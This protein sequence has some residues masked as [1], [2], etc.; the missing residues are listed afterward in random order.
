MGDVRPL[1]L[2]DWALRT[3]KADRMDRDQAVSRLD[4]LMSLPDHDDLDPLLLQL[5]EQLSAEPTAND[6]SVWRLIGRV[7]WNRYLTLPFGEDLTDLVAA[8]HS[9]H[10]VW[11]HDPAD[12]P[13][14]ARS[15]FERLLNDPMGVQPSIIVDAFLVNAFA[16]RVAY[17]DSATV[18]QLEEAVGAVLQMIGRTPD[19]HSVT[20]EGFTILCIA[21]RMQ[22][23]RT[24]QGEYIEDAVRYGERAVTVDRTGDASSS[25]TNALMR[26]YQLRGDPADLETA[27]TRAR[28][29]IVRG[30]TTAQNNLAVAL[31][32]RFTVAPNDSDA[33]EIVDLARRVVDDSVGTDDEALALVNLAINMA[34][35]SDTSY[36]IA[37][38]E[39]IEI[40]RR[41]LALAMPNSEVRRKALEM[42]IAG[43]RARFNEERNFD[44][45]D[46]ADQ[47]VAELA[48]LGGHDAAMLLTIQASL[49][50]TRWEETRDP[51]Q[52]ERSLMYCRAILDHVPVGHLNRPLH[53]HH[54]AMQLTT[55]FRNF[56]DPAYLLEAIA[57]H[58]S[59]LRQMPATH[60]LYPDAVNAVGNAYATLGRHTGD[61]AAYETA[62]KHHRALI[63]QTPS[64][65]PDLPDR[66]DSL[67]ASVRALGSRNGDVGLIDEALRYNFAAISAK[68]S[69]RDMAN[70]LGNTAD[71]FQTRFT[72][73]GAL[74]DIREAVIYAQRAVD[75]LQSDDPRRQHHVLRLG[76]FLRLKYSRT[77]DRDD[78]DAAIA[79]LRAA[80]AGL[81]LNRRQDRRMLHELSATLLASYSGPSDRATL[82]EAAELTRGLVDAVEKD[83]DSEVVSSRAL[84]LGHLCALLRRL[85]DVDRSTVLA[86][87]AVTTAERA[88]ELRNDAAGSP[89]EYLNLAEAL[90]VRYRLRRRRSD[91]RAALQTFERGGSNEGARLSRR[92]DC[93]IAGAQFAQKVGEL[94]RARAMYAKVLDLLP[95]LVEGSAEADDHHFRLSNVSMVGSRA[96]HAAIARS[97]HRLARRGQP[98]VD[99]W[100]ALEAGRGI[101]IERQLASKDDLSAL[102]AVAPEL[103]KRLTT[104]RRRQ[105]APA[106]DQE[107]ESAGSPVAELSDY[108]AIG[109]LLRAALSEARAIPGFE[110]FGRRDDGPLPRP[111]FAGDAVVALVHTPTDTFAL[112]LEKDRTRCIRLDSVTPEDI[113][114]RAAR[115]AVAA[116]DSVNDPQADD[117]LL[118]WLWDRIVEPVLRELGHRQ[119]P[120]PGSR[121]PRIWWMPTGAFALF[122]LHA[123]GHY[124]PGKKAPQRTALDRVVS[125]YVPTLRMLDVANNRSVATGSTAVVG[126]P[127][128]NERALPAL[129][130][131]AVEARVVGNVLAAEPLI[132]ADATVLAVSTSFVAV[133]NVHLACHYVPNLSSPPDSY[134]ALADG[135]LPISALMGGA[136]VQRNF[137]YLS[138]CAGAAPVGAINEGMHGAS[139]LMLAGF[140]HVVASMWPLSDHL[141]P[142]FA[143]AVYSA[144][145]EGKEPA[146]AVHTAVRQ[147]RTAMPDR[148]LLWASLMHF[149]R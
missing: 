113:A 107:G 67:A 39:Q 41:A 46:E 112:T 58:E 7:R 79:V 92:V 16:M 110:R 115:L 4:G 100:A 143:F 101:L 11:A 98:V 103:A 42:L 43:V 50:S 76:Q 61:E 23:E 89:F 69:S 102:A 117:G 149:G 141:A 66:Q 10:R 83:P 38:T 74:R 59:A 94:H 54:L 122:P 68:A 139:A 3:P 87:E 130:M 27:I 129:P 47:L 34:K 91:R 14:G 17:Q 93:L 82:V 134:L 26:R 6:V 1:P 2:A 33:T 97:R 120:E 105:L 8:V 132:N 15:L 24:G 30:D 131:A 28:D 44:D 136:E 124:V 22:Y 5:T 48:A 125:S 121:W 84:Y 126:V 147:M 36:R 77:E 13:D 99:A 60:T 70:F 80:T 20:A 146:E 31:T 56:G 133:P 114:Q 40:A 75:V 45:L 49:A 62:V 53:E 140:P 72:S 55:R 25:L 145:A 81:N 95:G 52:L 57:L 12:I 64:D 123:A 148:P 108:Y 71:S 127:V 37:P 19:R 119:P 78:I 29:G 144:I 109:G 32:M 138:S 85:A 9:F 137:A 106:S 116:F 111:A 21:R 118:P 35:L 142:G 18:G 88:L 135:R 73:T 63:E 51:A 104:L 96:A 128:S 65:H 90:A 86:N